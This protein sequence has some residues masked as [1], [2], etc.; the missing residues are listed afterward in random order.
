MYLVDGDGVV[1]LPS[2]AVLNVEEYDSKSP[3][4]G[5]VDLEKKLPV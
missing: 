1:L 4:E 5:A 2:V 3:L